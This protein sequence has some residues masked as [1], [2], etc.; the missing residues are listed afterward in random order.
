LF[1]LREECSKEPFARDFGVAEDEEETYRMIDN[2]AANGM[3]PSE[4]D[5]IIKS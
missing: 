1:D 3:K 5:L 2:M 4:A